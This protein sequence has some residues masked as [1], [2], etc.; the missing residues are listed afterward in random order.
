MDK[1]IRRLR[2]IIEKSE[3]GSILYPIKVINDLNIAAYE[4]FNLLEAI[5]GEGLIEAN[6]SLICKN[7][8]VY[9]ERVYETFSR[10]IGVK[11]C[12]TCGA[13]INMNNIVVVYRVI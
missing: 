11:L 8:P 12:P 1:N 13:N 5:K 3:K 4:A 7:T 9:S 10:A 6:Y 2:E